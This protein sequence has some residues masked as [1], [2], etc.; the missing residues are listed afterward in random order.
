MR[1]TEK[2]LAAEKEN[3]RKRDAGEW[4]FT[5]WWR[6]TLADGTIWCE[7]SSETEAR[8]RVPDGAVLQKLFEKRKTEWRD[9]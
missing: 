3:S 2:Q 9:A 7:T 1:L 8:D 6:V 5:G 4:F